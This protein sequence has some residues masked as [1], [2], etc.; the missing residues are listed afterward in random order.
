MSQKSSWIKNDK[1][2]SPQTEEQVILPNEDVFDLNDFA[3]AETETEKKP[4]F[5]KKKINPENI[6]AHKDEKY[7]YQPSEQNK[8]KASHNWFLVT[9]LMT[10]II[11]GVIYFYFVIEDKNTKI[12][13]LERQMYGKNEPQ[14]KGAREVAG[15]NNESKATVTPDTINAKNFSVST[16][17]NNFDLKTSEI[18]VSINYFN[19]QIGSKTTFSKDK[20]TDGKSDSIEILWAEKQD[21][22][23]KDDLVANILKINPEFELDSKPYKSANNISFVLLKP[24]DTLST[25]KIYTGVS[26]GF[27]YVVTIYNPSFAQNT[28]TNI[29]SFMENAISK[30]SFN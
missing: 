20:S 21:S 8:E 9:F 11:L 18:S 12:S 25:T 19:N 30:I 16:E 14:V 26:D 6:R 5:E 17:G 15:A 7:F 29:N 3:N 4:D 27:M 1:N 24:K 28:D 10:L 2:T 13:S 23:S 22:I